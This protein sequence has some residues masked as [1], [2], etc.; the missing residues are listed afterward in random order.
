MGRRLSV[1]E[2]RR[3]SRFGERQLTLIVPG[4]P[5]SSREDGG[6]GDSREDE[7]WRR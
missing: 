2:I 4:G 5:V 3:Q 1:T 6:G 7:A